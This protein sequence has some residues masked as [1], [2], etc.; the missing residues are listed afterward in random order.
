[1]IS[2]A[3]DDAVEDVIKAA[4]RMA[5]ALSAAHR[6]REQKYNEA[7]S[8]LHALMAAIHEGHEA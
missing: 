5:I 8:H 2:R 4:D 3:L 1:M 7:V 6:D